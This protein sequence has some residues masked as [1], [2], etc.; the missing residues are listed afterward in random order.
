M[1]ENK[2]FLRSPAAVPDLCDV[3]CFEE[4]V[5]RRVRLGKPDD[6]ALEATWRVFALLADRNRLLILHAL[7]EAGELCVCDLAHILGVSVS[8]TS[9]HLRRLFEFD[10]VES[11]REG[12]LVYYSLSRPWIADIGG[13]VL[14]KIV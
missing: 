9:H 10:L 6:A 1:R 8:A 12:K 5:V 3:P 11:R 2:T 13:K 7:R 14:E 4:D